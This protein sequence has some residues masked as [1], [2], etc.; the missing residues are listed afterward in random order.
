MT[1]DH[2]DNR[3]DDLDNGIVA[4]PHREDDTDDYEVGYGR[5]PKKHQ[6]QKGQSGNPKGR[7]IG[8][9]GLKSDLEEVVRAKVPVTQQGQKSFQTKQRVLL[10]RLVNE[11]LQ[12]NMKA[13]TQVLTM[14]VQILGVE[15]ERTSR[16]DLTPSEL[17]ILDSYLAGDLIS[18][19]ASDPC[20]DT[21]TEEPE[22]QADASGNGNHNN[23]TTTIVPDEESDNEPSC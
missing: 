10:V 13:A 6:F 8:A 21:P 11:A 14:I 18:A 23:I 9:R 22:L 20:S 3:T 1:D 5:P 19:D 17:D 7:R 16:T 12:G 2:D 15:D 4:D